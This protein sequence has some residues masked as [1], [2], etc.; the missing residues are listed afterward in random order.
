MKYKINNTNK[1]CLPTKWRFEFG[2]L[3][4]YWWNTDDAYN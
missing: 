1:A 3:L 4:W 2:C